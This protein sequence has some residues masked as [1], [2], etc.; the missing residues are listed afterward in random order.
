M[1]TDNDLNE[2]NLDVAI[3]NQG[4]INRFA[5][6]HTRGIRDPRT[7]RLMKHTDYGDD[8][9]LNVKFTVES[10][11]P[12]RKTYFAGGVPKCVD[13]DFIMITV[14]GNRDLIVHAQVTD[15]YEW[16]FPLEYAQFKRGQSAVVTGTSLDLSTAQ[17]KTASRG[18]NG[19]GVQG[20]LRPSGGVRQAMKG[21]SNRVGQ[22]GAQKITWW[23]HQ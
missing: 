3:A 20:V 2:I 21:G 17:H 15:F 1:S 4:G 7:G 13:M 19:I 8:V 14:P 23:L 9:G 11:F 22:C 10:V 12:K 5:E 6:E 16:R 18:S